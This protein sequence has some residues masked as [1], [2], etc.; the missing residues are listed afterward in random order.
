MTNKLKQ[1]NNTLQDLELELSR[2]KRKREDLEEV[3]TFG[4]TTRNKCD[5]LFAEIAHFWKGDTATR[6]LNN[7]YEDTAF[8]INKLQRDAYQQIEHL[9]EEE[10]KIKTTI[11][12][13]EDLYYQE[14]KR[15]L[16]EDN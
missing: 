15:L 16:E 12:T 1:I 14:K 6:F 10:R 4:Y 5:N 7:S 11:N 3:D 13:T 8:K 9:A 2:T